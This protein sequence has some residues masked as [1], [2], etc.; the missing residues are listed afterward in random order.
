MD[1]DD[2][3]QGHL[4]DCYFLSCLSVLADHPGMVE[5]LI[6]TPTVNSGGVFA[7]RFCKHG[8]WHDVL[9]DDHFPC[10]KRQDTDQQED[11]PDDED[12]H[13]AALRGALRFD[14]GPNSVQRPTHWAPAF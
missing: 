6:L 12:R 7:A 1:A 13:D 4:G 3:Q 9:I 10:V 2:I 8:A 14:G 11:M 5:R